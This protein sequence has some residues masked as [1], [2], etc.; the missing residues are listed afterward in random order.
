MKISKLQIKNF[1][2]I[3][4]LNF[5]PGKV[6]IIQGRVGKGKTS[7]LE[8][9][10]KGFTNQDRRP[11]V[12]RDGA[13]S[14]LIL[15]ETDTGFTVRRSITEKGTN[16][17][18]KDEKGFNAP[19]PQKLLSKLIGAFSFNPIDFITRDEKEQSKI[20]LSAAPVKVTPEEVQT[21]TGGNPPV[22]YNLHGL[23]VVR[24]LHNYYYERRREVNAEVKAAKNEVESISIPADFDPE[25]YRGVSL[26][27]LYDE[28]KAAQDNNEAITNATNGLA[29]LTVDKI[30]EKQ[31]AEE[32]RRKIRDMA[33]IERENVAD[34]ARGATNKATMQAASE[35]STLQNKIAELEAELKKARADLEQVDVTLALSLKTIEEKKMERLAAI[36]DKEKSLLTT[37]DDKERQSLV[38][39]EQ[40]TKE[41][42]SILQ[43]NQPIDLVP[44]EARVQEFEEKQALVRDFDRKEQAKARLAARDAEAKRLDQV[45]KTLAEKPQELIAR[46]NLPIQGIGI[47]A[48]GNVTINGRPIKSMSTGESI[49]FA[50]DV[51]RE[52]AGDLKLIC[53][54]GLERLDV[55]TR[56]RFLARISRPEDDCQY[57]CTQVGDGE[58][59][60]S[61][62]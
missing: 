57:F 1:L 41:F 17:T 42:E 8:A 23:Q 60:I 11:R 50:V 14:A 18:V 39:I 44:L 4:E 19:S 37:V 24:D 2:G 27:T 48:A 16:L 62:A 26:R 35:K 7:I 30:L 43:E 58:M 13:D 10:E 51:A 49:D 12:I 22:D 45:V 52:L 59:E 32:E 61:V 3:E 20:L 29:T 38:V 15:I 33:R 54:D 56:N 55:D 46:A 34:L 47:D 21:W 28:L 5:E 40:R 6:N 36:D 25:Q 53:V 9:I 31:K